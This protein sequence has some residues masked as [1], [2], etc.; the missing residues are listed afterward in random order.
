MPF[1][2]MSNVHIFA[3]FWFRMRYMI[4]IYNIIYI[5]KYVYIYNIYIYKK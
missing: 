1:V 2:R 4:Y 5:Y 3:S